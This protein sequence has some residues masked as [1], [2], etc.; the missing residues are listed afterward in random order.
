VAGGGLH[1]ARVGGGPDQ[2][3]IRGGARHGL[4]QG[5]PRRG[6]KGLKRHPFLD[7]IDPSRWGNPPLNPPSK[8]FLTLL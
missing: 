4:R 8:T 6:V 1:R 7:T 5:S 3:Q 2:V